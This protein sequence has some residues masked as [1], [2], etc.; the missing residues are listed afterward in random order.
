MID[1]LSRISTEYGS[2]L[3]T[4]VGRVSYSSGVLTAVPDDPARTHRMFFHIVSTAQGDETSIQSTVNM[5]GDVISISRYAKV[6]VGALVKCQI[7]S[8]VARL[9]GFTCQAYHVERV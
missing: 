6:P 7:T 1:V 8:M 4:V 3:P 2:L 5:V 9:R